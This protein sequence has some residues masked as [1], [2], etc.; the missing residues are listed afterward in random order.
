MSGILVVAGDPSGDLHGAGLIRELKTQ[1]PDL[2]VTALGG[3]RMQAEADEF[4]FDL[5][6]RGIGGFIDPFTQILFIK[7]VLSVIR[8][9]LDYK[10]PGAVVV[11]DFYGFNHQVLG[12]AKHRSLPSY[13]YISPQVWASR[14]YRIHKLKRLVEKMLLIFPFEVPLYRD[15]GVPCT[16]VGHPLL[17]VLPEPHAPEPLDGRPLRVGLLPGSRPSELK[18]HM[19][20]FLSA[21]ERIR[22][23]FPDAQGELFAS[24]NIPDEMLAPHL[25]GRP[26]VAIVRESDYRRRSRLD[27]ALTASGTATLENALLGVPMVVAYRINW[28]TYLIAKAIVKIPRVAMANILA[29]RD[30]A[31]EFIQTEASLSN[32]SA[33]CLE[34]LDDPAR[35]AANRADLL[36]L[37]ASLGGPGAAKRAASIVLESLRAPAEASKT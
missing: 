25:E 13:Y 11:I 5:A 14:P 26:G 36:A 32:V 8:R 35:L 19:D 27:F 1:R 33:A 37:R 7:R 16:F 17:D 30:L 2:Q 9:H 12:L 29:G 24:K 22:E 10:R 20:L 23:R 34:I 21:F 6:S 28:P 31:P 18:R 3:P 15:A 4:L